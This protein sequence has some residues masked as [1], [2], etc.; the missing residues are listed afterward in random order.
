[1]LPL[2]YHGGMLR[3]RRPGQ[4]TITHESVEAF[5]N[6]EPLSG[7]HAIAVGTEWLDVKYVDRQ[8]ETTLVCF[9]SALTNRVRVLPAFSGTG[10][11]EATGFNLVALADPSIACGDLDLAWFLGTRGM[12]PLPERLSLIVRHLLG[13]SSPI[14][15]GASGGGYA[16][17]LYGQHFPDQTVVSV[18]PRLDLT[19][20]PLPDIMRYLRVAHSCKSAASLGRAKEKFIPPPLKDY[21]SGGLTFDL[22]I[23]QNSN[24]G[25]YRRNQFEPFAELHS[26]DPR[27]YPVLYD[28]PSGHSVID[29]KYLIDYLIS[30]RASA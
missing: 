15:F 28:G 22:H 30:L 4:E 24:D 3:V 13:S 9:H 2:G 10:V 14:L 11:S 21:Y 5:I 26:T 16:S 8:A 29:A 25:L 19:Q 18:N 7:S 23:L 17:V 20:P 6:T 12:G 27:F 1:M